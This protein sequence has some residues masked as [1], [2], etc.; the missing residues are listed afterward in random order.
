MSQA[1]LPKEKTTYEEEESYIS[2]S[3]RN[4][5]LFAIVV[6]GRLLYLQA[7]STSECSLSISLVAPAFGYE[8]QEVAELAT[9]KTEELEIPKPEEQKQDFCAPK[10]LVG[11]LAIDFD[12]DKLEERLQELSE[13]NKDFFENGEHTPENC[14]VQKLKNIAIII[15]FRDMTKDLFRTKQLLYF[16]Y[17][18]VPILHRQNNHFSIYLVNQVHD[19]LP[20]NRA[21]LLNI[22]FE[23]AKKDGFDCFFFH[24]VDLVPENDQNIYECFDNPRHYSGFIDKF[25]YNLPYNSIF[26]GIT[27]YSA[28][29]FHKINGYSNEYW[30]WGGEDD[31]L[32]RRTIAGAKYKLLR[33]EAG[34]SH[35]KMIKHGHETSNKP[36]PNRQKLLKAWNNH[37][38]FDG[39]NSLNYK[40]IERSN[41]LFFKNITVDLKYSERIPLEKLLGG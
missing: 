40:L 25:N 28:E 39:L 17:Y 26:G 38:K 13:N 36:N 5:V 27:A 6:L 23:I 12:M 24:D 3:F 22:G 33:P 14:Q 16:L 35:Y 7:I 8:S 32:E 31:D 2:C 19:D 1:L 41:D 18:M 30:G 21:K 11:A 34:K 4:T 9:Q 10:G 15:P 29:A 20:F 37:A